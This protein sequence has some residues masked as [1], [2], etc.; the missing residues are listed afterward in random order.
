M[1]S[2]ISYTVALVSEARERAIFHVVIEQPKVHQTYV[3]TSNK[4]QGPD[5][6]NKNA[7]PKQTCREPETKSIL[8][9]FLWFVDRILFQT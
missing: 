1:R 4:W 6:F 9:G 7:I 5:I 3:S 8:A 2:P